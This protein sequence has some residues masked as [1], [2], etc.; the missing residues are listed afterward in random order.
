[1]SCFHFYI[2]FCTVHPHSRSLFICTAYI[3][4]CL[5]ENEADY[6]CWA[7]HTVAN[8]CNLLNGGNFCPIWPL[9]RMV[10]QKQISLYSR[11]DLTLA[12]FLRTRPLHS[13]TSQLCSLPFPP[14]SPLPLSIPSTQFPFPTPGPSFILN[15]TQQCDFHIPPRLPFFL[16]FFPWSISVSSFHAIFI[17][18]YTFGPFLTRTSLSL[19]PPYSPHL[20][21]F[22]ALSRFFFYVSVKPVLLLSFTPLLFF[23]SSTSSSS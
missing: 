11:P 10:I 2:R 7:V 18:L 14:P 17:N 3:E 8:C 22:P 15:S 5:W 16:I 9:Q 12:R 20:L 23:P 19:R 6:N 21:F 1:M 4:D 13:L